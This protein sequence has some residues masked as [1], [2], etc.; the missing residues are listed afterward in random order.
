MARNPT[1]AAYISAAIDRSTKTNAEIA[2]ETGLRLPNMV[3]MIKQGT[4]KLPV[5]RITSFAKA[6]DLDPGEL[7]RL[8]MEEYLPDLLTVCDEIYSRDVSKS[9][10]AL[11][12]RLRLHTGGSDFKVTKAVNEAIDSLGTAITGGS[13]R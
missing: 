3:S 1:V 11:L 10:E 7:F 12:K 8:V 2:K 6:L 13:S 4:T 9:E 5:G